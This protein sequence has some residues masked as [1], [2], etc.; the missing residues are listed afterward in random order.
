MPV[1]LFTLP[2]LVGREAVLAQLRSAVTR[3]NKGAG[4]CVVLEGTAGIGKSSL[5]K[6][7][8]NMA[9]D[10]GLAVALGN[11]SEF[12]Q[13]APLSTLMSALSASDVA[14]RFFDGGTDGGP[15]WLVNRVGDL[16]ESFAG[17]QALVIALDDAHWADELTSFALRVLVPGLSQYPVL[18]LLARRPGAGRRSAQD[19]I[20]RLLEDHSVRLP[21][22]PLDDDDS[23]ELCA[24]LLGAR[25]D[26]SLLAD[27]ARSR[28]NPFLAE[29]L[30]CTLRDAGSLSVTRGVAQVS[31]SQLPATFI[32]AVDRRLRDLSPQA[33]RILEAGSV[34]GRPFTVHEVAALV[35]LPVAGV[36][37][38]A[39]E[40]V[41]TEALEDGGHE[42]AFRHDLIR[43]AVYGSLP[44]PVRLALHREAATVVRD[45]GRSALEVAEH[46][47][48]GGQVG[49]RGAIAVLRDA[50][51]HLAPRAPGT[52]ADMLMRALDLL[53]ADDGERPQLI[54]EAVQ[55]LACAGRVAEARQLGEQALEASN[56]DATLLLGLSE[57][58]KHAGHNRAVV[59]YTVAA[60]G[61]PD[62]KE[63][64]RAQLLAIQAHAL[65]RTESFG[66]ARAAADE[67]VRLGQLTDHQDAVVFGTSARA[68]VALSSGQVEAALCDARH[69]VTI[70]DSKGGESAQR[71]PRL[72][73]AKVLVSADRFA[74]ADAVLEMDQ[75]EAERL[76]T[77]WSQ[78]L[79][80]YYRAELR[81]AAGRL[82]D[83]L[84]D[85][86]AGVRV[87]EQ[88]NALALVVPLLALLSHIWL[89]RQ[90][91]A[92][93]RSHL[94]EAK[95]LIDGGISVGPEELVWRIALLE[96]A[97]G[98][99]EQAF[100]TL[101]DVFAMLPDRLQILNEP[102]ASVHLVRIA[103][104][105][106]EHAH[107]ERA[108]AAAQI[109]AD[110][111]PNVASFG[112]AAA[113]A[114]GVLR[115]DVHALHEATAAYR[116]SPRP[117]ERAAAIV[118]TA[119][120][121]DALDNRTEAI[122]LLKEAG[123][124]YARIGA[125]RES[126]RVSKEL[127]RLGVR[128]KKRRAVESDETWGGLTG[129]E[130][131]VVQLVAEGLTNRQV[132]ARLFLSRHTVDSHIRHSFMKLGVNC[133]VELTRLV[134]SKAKVTDQVPSVL[135]AH[136]IT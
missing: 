78:P 19:A 124:Q 23:A 73:L 123:D 30:L 69:A 21:I 126:A 96:E 75:R 15:M 82:D 5:L 14:P 87:A 61:M 68:C 104:Q 20:D 103:R 31:T 129:S 51:K 136:Q 1:S 33:H 64:L 88:S 81:L 109:L 12:D 85:A 83:A 13:S 47:V 107:A 53:D 89:Q 110:R 101:S 42:L 133:R 127:Q 118:D 116:L 114:R 8:L 54:A 34:L 95:Q 60:L 84:A 39:K 27:V 130:L 125:D 67:A 35:G 11:T 37:D 7:T 62:L 76:G 3:A 77:A 10:L 115:S 119:L 36:I 128:R 57:T 65:L 80:H 90:D 28:G 92:K 70:A 22:D 86:Q 25:P 102:G 106:G 6:A 117:L 132:A 55:L 79:W 16:I 72:W 48:C 66:L 43:E 50:V 63:S 9:S 49:D 58:L 45:E 26:E 121:E 105:A 41:Q 100:R 32:D 91:I 46:L 17:S 29:E 108:V 112:A 2:P 131:R 113:H 40:A 134:V 94:S 4:G 52:A 97:E 135:A 99:P 24:N 56:D 18:W 44:G 74:E 122:Q 98:C 38:A 111:N 59:H 71:H 120:A 93:T